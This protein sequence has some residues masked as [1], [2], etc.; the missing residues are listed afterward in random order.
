MPFAIFGSLFYHLYI[1]LLLSVLCTTTLLALLCV[2]FVEP[3]ILPSEYHGCH[4]DRFL[5]LNPNQSKT[6]LQDH[7]DDQRLCQG[8]EELLRTVPLLSMRPGLPLTKNPA[9]YLKRSSKRPPQAR[10][11]PMP[12]EV[13][14]TSSSSTGCINNENISSGCWISSRPEIVRMGQMLQTRERGEM[15]TSDRSTG[16]TD[17]PMMGSERN[18]DVSLPNETIVMGNILRAEENSRNSSSR[19][20]TRPIDM[21]SIETIETYPLPIRQ[22]KFRNIMYDT[23][24]WPLRTL[25]TRSQSPHFP[26]PY[27]KLSSTMDT[28]ISINSILCDY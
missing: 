8:T 10:T 23:R 9:E 17:L 11:M 28:S 22:T 5:M 21:R 26:C 18:V 3:P 16:L 7:Q 20:P 6:K 1:F 12:E 25:K 24:K 14:L 19:G 27:G 15:N 13:L 2:N 4:C